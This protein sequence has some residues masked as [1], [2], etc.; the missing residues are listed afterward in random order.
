MKAINPFQERSDRVA[1]TFVLYYQK[2]KFLSCYRLTDSTEIHSVLPLQVL[3]TAV[4]GQVT[5]RI[6]H[7]LLNLCSLC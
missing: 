1:V 3:T 7:P 2:Q 6:S 5:D 4:H